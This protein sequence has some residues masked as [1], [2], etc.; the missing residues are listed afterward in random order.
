MNSPKMKAIIVT[1]YGSPEV[2]QMKE[3]PKPSPEA[4]EVLIKI[5]AT[6]VTAADSMMRRADPFISRF[7]LGFK[8]PKQAIPG[9]GFA[10]VIEAVGED[11]LNFQIG[12]AVFGETAFHFSAHAEYV[13]VPEAGVLLKKPAEISFEEAAPVCDGALT[14][15]NFLESLGKIQSWQKVLIN[16][17]SGSLGTAAVQLARSYG[18]EVTGVC[19]TANV[20]LVKSLGADHVIDYTREDF[21]QNGQQYD[22]IYDTV[23]KSSF[24]KCKNVL[25]E[26]G[27]YLSPV[28]KLPLL[29]QMIRTS[30]MGKKK[31][32]F[33]ATGT[34]PAEKLRNMLKEVRE[35]MEAGELKSV[36]D[37]R[38]S[39]AEIVEAHRYVDG[40]RKR[41]NVVI[42]VA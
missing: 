18:A 1:Q 42:Q 33:S 37:Q 26:N 4:N 5:H 11:V 25:T 41:G 12:D 35:L 32:L 39:L 10:G 21:T 3:V 38:F 29:F 19:S 13:C 7:F 9:T 28:L 22:L 15:M 23:G 31:A 16:G 27:K 34:L 40:G 8:R 36:I 14:S 24:S 30:L 6:A 2:L 17:A 20:E